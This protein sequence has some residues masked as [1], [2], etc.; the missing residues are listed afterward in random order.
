LNLSGFVPLP[1]GLQLGFNA[2]AYSAT[3]FSAYVAGVDFNGDG[4]QN[5]LLPGTRINQFGRG[6]DLQD[7]ERLV[8]AY[9]E[10]FARRP[11]LGGQ[12]APLVTLPDN[13]A[14]D[15]SFFVLDVRLGRSFALPRSPL[16]LALFGEVFNLLNTAN[17]VGFNGNLASRSF[18]QP[19]SRFTQVFGSGGPRAAQ[20]GARVSF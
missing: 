16:R 10:K 12:L 17:L 1:W 3:P 15:D 18:G 14:F 11:T 20:I 9:N 2:S 6:L 5:D 19:T 7:L 4:T 13:Y 8:A